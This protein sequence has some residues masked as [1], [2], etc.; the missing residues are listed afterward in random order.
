MTGSF[1]TFAAFNLAGSGTYRGPVPVLPTP[2]RTNA[3]VTADTLPRITVC[4]SHGKGPEGMNGHPEETARMQQLLT[5][6]WHAPDVEADSRTLEELLGAL[7]RLV[8]ADIARHSGTRAVPKRPGGSAGETRSAKTRD[9]CLAEDASAL[10]LRRLWETLGKMKAGRLPPVT[11][12]EALYRYA[13]QTARRAWYEVLRQESRQWNSV[14]KSILTWIQGGDTGY[15]VWRLS[16]FHG[17]KLVGPCDQKGQ[18]APGVDGA[19]LRTLAEATA[20]ALFPGKPAR[21][22]SR[23]EACRAVLAAAR[24]P[25]PLNDLTA[26]I[27]ALQGWSE[28]VRS[29]D[30]DSPD[31]ASRLE[32]ATAKSPVEHLVEAEDVRCVWETLQQ[33]PLNY[34]RVLLLD[35]DVI[36]ML[37]VYAAVPLAAMAQALELRPERLATLVDQ[38]PLGDSALAELTGLK[39][40]SVRNLRVASRKALRHR[41]RTGRRRGVDETARKMDPG[42][43]TSKIG[44]DS[45]AS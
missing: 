25:V 21:E 33:L 40:Q 30:E 5:R 37:E 2:V 12:A 31:L 27:C 44:R 38:M 34:R 24:E 8:A 28:P 32:D 14:R 42:P 4:W 45:S 11:S 3:G 10:A 15:A 43:G 29:L 41:L 9:E 13:T 36:E 7:E 35:A 19:A 39:L 26:A 6:F 22:L 18:A 17:E 23:V 1:A 16:P 20:A